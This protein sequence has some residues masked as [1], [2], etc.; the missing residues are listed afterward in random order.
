MDW[1]S[2]HIGLQSRVPA[3]PLAGMGASGGVGGWQGASGWQVEW[4]PNHIGPQF[5]V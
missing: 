5:R 2:G 1:E 4:E 3:F